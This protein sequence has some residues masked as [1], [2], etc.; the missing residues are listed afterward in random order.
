MEQKPLIFN[1][2]EAAR[3]RNRRRH[4]TKSIDFK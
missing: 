2:G 4:T 1:V 3:P